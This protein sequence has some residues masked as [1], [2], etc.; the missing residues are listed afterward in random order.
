MG[1]CWSEPPIQQTPVVSYIQYCKTCGAPAQ[2]RVEYCEKCLQRNAMYTVQPSAPPMNQYQV[3]PQYTYAYPM[4]QQQQQQQQQ[5]YYYQPPYQ[6]PQVM[7]TQQR[8][9][10][11]GTAIATGFLVGAVMEDILDPMD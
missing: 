3:Y 9:M 11:T 10:G 5:A 2:S 6:Q 1:I 4:P 7:Q 8:Q